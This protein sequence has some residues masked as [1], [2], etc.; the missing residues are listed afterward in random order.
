MGKYTK[1][2][3]LKMAAPYFSQG[4][5][6]MHATDDGNFFYE[7]HKHHAHNHS[8]TTKTQRYELTKGDFD[9]LAGEGPSELEKAEKELAKAKK[10]LEDRKTNEAKA[11]A[12]IKVDEC[13]AIV[14][15]L[16]G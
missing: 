1:E 14:D 15:K 9:A 4:E 16:K 10:Y 6:V 7:A 3:L 11:K 8:V 5:K 13:Q 2:E 12:Q